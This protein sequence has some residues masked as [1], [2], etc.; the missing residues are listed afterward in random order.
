MNQPQDYEP[1]DYDL[2]PENEGYRLRP[3]FTPDEGQH[4]PTADAAL[5]TDSGENGGRARTVHLATGD[6]HLAE[7][8]RVTSGLTLVGTGPGSIFRPLADFCGEALLD[9][10]GVDRARL[11]G[12]SVRGSHQAAFRKSQT[13]G[14]RLASAG[15]CRIEDILCLNLP[16]DGIR[17]EDN[18]FLC[19]IRGCRLGECHGA[20][21]R[22]VKNARNGRGGDYVPNL[23]TQCMACRGGTGFALDNSLVI[24]LVGCAVHQSRGP[25]FHVFNKSNSVLLSGCRTFQI[26]DHAVLVDASHEINI[27]GNIFCWHEGNGIH[28]REV[29]WGTV[30]GN[31]VIDT[32]SV[33]LDPG[34]DPAQREKFTLP[35]PENLDLAG[36]AKDGIHVCEASKNL[37]FTGNAVFNW[38][39]NPPM[40][41]GIFADD[42][43][44]TIAAT[45]NTI[46]Y[47]TQSDAVRLEGDNCEAAANT[48]V[49]HPARIGGASG[50][51]QRFDTT[52]IERFLREEAI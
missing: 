8:V 51:C 3:R 29:V 42:S 43:C 23:V 31:N 36:H 27:T 39:V 21:V 44:D 28:F 15:D 20:G 14:I 38:G 30:T 19:E 35:T 40:R 37:S 12:F 41:H 17:L 48:A 13:H 52:V 11:A 32:G 34:P 49:N 7:A 1:Q 6:F 10:Q 4:F 2:F 18:S 16:G 46:N 33:N 25:G 47:I 5:N 50:G 9:G 22:L 26:E 45:G 24:N